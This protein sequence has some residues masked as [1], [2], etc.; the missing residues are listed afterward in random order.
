MPN[1]Q[2]AAGPALWSAGPPEPA[3]SPGSGGTF[4]A[5]T[6]GAVGAKAK[7]VAKAGNVTRAIARLLPGF[8]KLCQHAF[9]FSAFE[10]FVLVGTAGHTAAVPGL[11]VALNLLV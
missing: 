6:R 1:G 5:W 7:D 4:G 2:C 8:V 11:G 9:G 10:Q 3:P